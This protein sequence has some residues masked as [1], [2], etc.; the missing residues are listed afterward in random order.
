MSSTGTFE[1][2][3]EHVLV[4]VTK[5]QL[6]RVNKK[7]KQPLVI[8]TH[9]ILVSKNHTLGSFLSDAGGLSGSWTQTGS[10]K[11]EGSE[12][13]CH[14]TRDIRSV[15]WSHGTKVQLAIK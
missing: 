12:F 14:D 2:I 3:S 1:I 13:S 8:G 4:V 10:V 7:S 9:N 5:V 15:A 11:A 6:V